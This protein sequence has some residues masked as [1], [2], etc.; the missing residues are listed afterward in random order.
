MKYE[1]ISDYTIKDLGVIEED[2]Y[3]LEIEDDH[4]FFGNDI[5]LHNSIFLNF[6]EV[7]Q[8]R[9]K[10]NYDETPMEEKRDFVKKISKDLVDPIIKDY[11]ENLT[12]SLNCPDNTLD[13]EMEAISDKSLFVAKKKYVMNLIHNDGYDIDS[14]SELK[15]RGMEIIRTSTPKVI[16][17]ELKKATNIILYSENND[18][19]INFVKD[20]K[21]KFYKMPFEDIAF[22]RGVKFSDYVFG[23]KGVP[24]HVRSSFVFNNALKK[25][26][27]NQI[28]PIRNA[29]KI[30]FC[31]IKEPNVFHSNVIGCLE[32]MPPSLSEKFLIDYETQFEKTCISPLKL[33]IESMGWTT[34]QSTSMSDLW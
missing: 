16:R 1:I 24:I 31:Y 23:G 29:D 18:D 19:L 4:N 7:I 12:D 3:D 6:D 17:E 15:I 21:K 8:K 28:E 14:G 9:Y 20:F 22:P 26:G 30:K 10:E 11:Y 33:M 2:V 32:K 34:E 25:Y 5:L 13:M 27:L